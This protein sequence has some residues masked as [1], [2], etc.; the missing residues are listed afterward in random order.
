MSAIRQQSLAT[1]ID[2]LHD[3]PDDLAKRTWLVQQLNDRNTAE[4]VF[5][6]LH[7][8]E[9]LRARPATRGRFHLRHAGLAALLLV[10]V[11]AT[12]IGLAHREIPAPTAAQPTAFVLGAGHSQLPDGSQVMVSQDGTVAVQHAAD[13][14][15]ALTLQTGS[16]T[17]QVV[18]Q[19]AGRHFTV[20]TVEGEVAVVG[21]KF[22]VEQQ[23][24]ATLVHVEEG[25][26]AVHDRT[27]GVTL[28]LGAGENARLHPPC[29]PEKT[30]S[31]SG[32]AAAPTCTPEAPSGITPD[33]DPV[34][35]PPSV[36]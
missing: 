5:R 14:A 26:V 11:G 18:H 22:Q 8:E 9:R 7:L 36:P 27:S 20:H 28:M 13:G 30:G 21:T 25:R 2:A 24:G 1:A 33:T 10:G 15:L 29:A 31:E 32:P 34:N 23:D 35:P 3:A 17:C 12:A 16:V 4:M 19:E 6:R